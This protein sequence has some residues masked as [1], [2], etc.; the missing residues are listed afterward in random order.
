MEFT[1]N[2]KQNIRQQYHKGEMSRHEIILL[3]N[4]YNVLKD[5]KYQFKLDYDKIFK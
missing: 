5:T 1:R 3:Q 4:S 2:K